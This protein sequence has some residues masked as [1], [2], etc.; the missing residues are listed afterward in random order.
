MDDKEFKAALDSLQTMMHGEIQIKKEV[1]DK[2][3]S[4]HTD[5]HP[6]FSAYL[7]IDAFEE[8]IYRAG[9]V[10]GKMKIKLDEE[11]LRK[12]MAGI[13]EQIIQDI[14][15]MEREERQ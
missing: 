12:M 4:I 1:G 6:F 13:S 15:K 8:M 10:E 2:A 11:T 3:S 5:L 14:S 9:H 7:L